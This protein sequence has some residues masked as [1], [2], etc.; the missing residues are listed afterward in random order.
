[1]GFLKTSDAPEKENMENMENLNSPWCVKR[2]F[3]MSVL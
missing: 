1:M 2:E 3:V